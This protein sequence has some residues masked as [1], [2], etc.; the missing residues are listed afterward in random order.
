MTIWILEYETQSGTSISAWL[1]EDLARRAMR[2]IVKEYREEFTVPEHLTDAAAAYDW[3]MLTG[4]LEAM[5]VTPMAVGDE[6]AADAYV[7]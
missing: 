3:F 5:R 4:G 1:R 2:R 7:G 6:A